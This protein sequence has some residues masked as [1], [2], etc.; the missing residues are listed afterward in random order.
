MAE[1]KYLLTIEEKQAFLVFNEV[2][3]AEGAENLCLPFIFKMKVTEGHSASGLAGLFGRF[4][5]HAH[6]ATGPAPGVF[7]KAEIIDFTF[8][9]ADARGHEAVVPFSV[10]RVSVNVLATDAA[11]DD[12]WMRKKAFMLVFKVN[13][14]PI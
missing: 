11:K 3:K 13:D 14:A 7:D 9:I 1:G 5:S 8:G 6:G 2:A 10:P 4:A 12:D